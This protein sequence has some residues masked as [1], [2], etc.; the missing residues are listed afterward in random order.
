[1]YLDTLE[2]RL[3]PRTEE[4][5]YNLQLNEAA[6]DI[7]SLVFEFKVLTAWQI[8]RFLGHK[9]QS[10]YLYLKL[11]RVWQAGLLESFKVYTG[12][13]A[14]MPVY[15]MLSKRGLKLLAE[16][17][18]YHPMLLKSYPQ[19]KT[20]FSW[21]IF[22]HEIQVA[23]LA[24][25]E[26]KNGSKSF[27]IACKG[28]ASSVAHDFRSEKSVEVFTPDY[29]V[30]YRM[31]GLE[32][33]IYTEFERTSKSTE[34]MGRK[35]ERYLLHLDQKDREHTTL[36]FIFQNPQ[37]EQAFWR[38]AFLHQAGFLQKLRVLSTNLNLL[39]SHEHFLEPIYVSEHTA[40][41]TKEGS[42]GVDLSERTKLFSFL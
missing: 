29:T 38:N 13:R 18:K 23:E 33:R 24:S 7:L 22:R 4:D 30:F 11:R 21:G 40:K 2:V 17:G 12:S 3:T 1:M 20:L 16:K 8:A 34:N 6:L 37:M 9:D 41:L 42:L 14:G 28:E 15:Y 26:V 19:A 5:S 25:Q 32:K 31:G 10:K 35:I 27:A 36:R 39:S